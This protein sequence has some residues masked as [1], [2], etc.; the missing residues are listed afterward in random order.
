MATG[1]HL[2]FDQ[3]SYFHVC[4]LEL[5][6]RRVALLGLNS[7]WLSS[8]DKDEAEGVVVGERQVQVALGQ[9]IDADLKIVLLHH[10][11]S[12]VRGSSRAGG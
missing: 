4:R 8:S 7:A 3:D 5:L 2:P 11:P 9:S 12:M 1:E 6:G 10:L